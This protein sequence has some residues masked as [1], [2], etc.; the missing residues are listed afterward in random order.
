MYVLFLYLFV[1]LFVLYSAFI[2]IHDYALNKN[3]CYIILLH[4]R[5]VTEGHDWPVTE[6]KVKQRHGDRSLVFL[7]PIGVNISERKSG[8]ERTK[9]RELVYFPPPGGAICTIVHRLESRV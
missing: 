9:K 6:Q 8:T 2:W 1:C 4:W 3:R 7:T 5:D